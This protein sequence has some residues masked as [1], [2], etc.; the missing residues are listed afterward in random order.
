MELRLLGCAEAAVFPL[1]LRKMSDS[2]DSNFSEEEDSERS[3]EAEEAEVSDLDSR[4][5]RCVW[6]WG[7]GREVPVGAQD[8][9]RLGVFRS[10]GEIGEQATQWRAEGQA[11]E[12]GGAPGSLTQY[13]MCSDFIGFLAS[14][15]RFVSFSYYYYLRC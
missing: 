13:V 15:A 6:G 8:S 4:G 10:S 14:C 5:R 2:E 1:Q 11:L 3:S 7:Q 9:E 12:G